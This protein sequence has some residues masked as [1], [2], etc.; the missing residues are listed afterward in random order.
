MSDFSLASLAQYGAPAAVVIGFTLLGLLVQRALLPYLKRLVARSSWRLDD[1]LVDA[2]SRPL[3]FWFVLAGLRAAAEMLPLAPR[4][5][6]LVGLGILVLA[7]LSVTWA[8]ARFAAGAVRTTS[9]VAGTQNVS[10]LA[11]VAQWTV[12]V[13]GI[14][15][16]LQTLGVRI[17][18]VITALGI[19]GLAVGLALQDTL[20]NFFSGIRIL[21]ARKIRPGDFV[22]LETG[23][24]GW[25]EDISWGQTVVRQPTNNIVLVPNARLATAI[26]TNYMLPS[27]PHNVVV[28]LGVAYGS[29][30]DTVERVTLEAGRET[31]RLVPQAVAEWEPILRWKE[32]GASSI[33]FFFVL[34]AQSYPQR[35]DVVTDFIKRLH[36][37]Y[38]QEGIEI[39]FPIRTVVL[40]REDDE[41]AA[42]PG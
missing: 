28:Q 5:A 36:R 11:S 24:D 23:Q 16:A 34:Q 4:P 31:Q 22:V 20:A 10:L 8:L 37:R 19:G 2:L 38:A 40:K 26:T 6:R 33:N 32:F 41:A 18:P 39:P 14:L 1:L 35:W 21:A 12:I 42:P 17:T 7:I 3:V 27:L 9:G 13:V 30:L 15:V 29:D 25:I